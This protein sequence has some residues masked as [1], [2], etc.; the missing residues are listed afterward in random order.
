MNAQSEAEFLRLSYSDSLTTYQQVIGAKDVVFW[1]HIVLTTATRAQAELYSAL[2]EARRAEG[3]LPRTGTISIEVDRNEQRIGSGGSTLCVLARLY[4]ESGCDMDRLLC[5]RNLILHSGGDAK[6]LPHSAP[7]GKI[8]ALS[9]SNIWGDVRNLPGTVF[10]DLMVS[11]AGVPSR[12]NG[13]VLIVSADAFF[14]FS[15]TQIDLDT[16][17]TVAFSMKAPVEEG[18]QHGVFLERD[19]NGWVSQFL[20]KLSEE[21]LRRNGAVSEFD[22]VDLDIGVTY[23]GEDAIRVLLGLVVDSDGQIDEAKLDKYANEAVRLSFYGDLI[24]PMAAES[25]RE[26]YLL[27]A[28]DGPLTDQL[29]ALRPELFELLH[30]CR[31]RLCRLSPG[32]ICNLGT[33]EEA[34]SARELMDGLGAEAPEQTADAGIS[35]IRKISGSAQVGSE[36]FIENSRIGERVV[37]GSHCLISNCDLP[38]GFVVDENI[39]LHCVKLKSGQWVCR[40]WGI[41]DGIKTADK[42]LNRPFAAADWDAEADSLWQARLFPVCANR[43]SA[44]EWAAKLMRGSLSPEDRA[45]WSRLERLSLSD[46][47]EIDALWLLYDRGLLE[48]EVR[49]ES[50]IQQILRGQEPKTAAGVLGAGSHAGRR[51]TLLL[52]R[53][54]GGCFARWQDA[55]R[56]LFCGA[57]AIELL[58][59]DGHS[60]QALRERGLGVLRQATAAYTPKPQAHQNAVRWSSALA[61][62]RLPIRVNWGGTWSDAPP[63]CFEH[64][65][66]M[67]NAA[68][69]LNGKLPVSIR[70]EVTDEPTVCFVNRQAGGET[71][72]DQM[73]PLLQFSDPGD[74]YILYKTALSVSG[75]ITPG[76]GSLEEQLTRL[77]GGVRITTDVNIPRGSGLGTSSILEAGLIQVLYRLTGKERTNAELSDD[78][79]LAEQLMTTGGGWQDVIGGVYPGVKLT[80]T[81]PGIPQRYDVQELVLSERALSELNGRGFLLYTGQRRLARSVLR[82]VIANYV[83]NH[84]ESLAALEAMQRLAVAMAYELRRE[85][86]GSFGQLLSEHMRLLRQLDA[87][88]SNRSLDYMMASLEEFTDGA[89]LCGAAGGGF[90]YGVLRE[91]VSRQELQRGIDSRFSGMKVYSASIVNSFGGISEC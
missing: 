28:G 18:T 67:L 64:G 46:T 52:E 45:E 43:E 77:G 4:R 84:R 3:V 48:D 6:R 15:D 79:L 32:M 78:V 1:D 83:C 57:E 87:S 53:I 9:G 5:K 70:A 86:V 54:E 8:F 90:L 37:L 42:W 11:F 47:K 85:N 58:G 23:L 26:A 72:F 49:T 10:D 40:V 29:K 89:T 56:L 74:R 2:I 66:T 80:Y 25:I 38:E 16:V 17:D 55:M 33:S 7:F 41:Q 22:T 91:H 59:I 35:L 60:P 13:G 65:G 27:E 51:I 44:L 81:E 71:R 20:H 36:C 75:V 61:E 63:F 31:L 73:E 69:A 76:G 12:M 24:Y 19:G 82:R 14:R 34:L 21:E 62:V 88:S 50:F 30:G 39:A 68:V